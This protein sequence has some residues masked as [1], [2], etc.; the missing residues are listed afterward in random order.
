MATNTLY[1]NLVK[2]DY[3]EKFDIATINQNM[4]IIDNAINS[5]T[6][7][8]IDKPNGI[9]SNKYLRTGA[10][11]TLEWADAIN[12]ADIAEAV[13]DWIEE[14]MPQGQTLAVD[15]TLSVAGAAAESKTTGDRLTA[16]QT[17]LTQQGTNLGNSKADKANTVLT[18]TLSRG[19]AESTTA[20]EGSF[21]FGDNVEASGAYSTATGTDTTASGIGAT[22]EGIGTTANLNYMHAAGFYNQPGTL[23]E[24]WRSGT[25]YHQGDIRRY[26]GNNCYRCIVDNSDSTFDEAKWEQVPYN[27]DEVFVV[28]NGTEDALSNALTVK[29]SGDVLTGGNVYAGGEKLATLSYVQEVVDGVAAT[30]YFTCSTIQ[31]GQASGVYALVIN[32]AEAYTPRASDQMI[33][34][35][36]QDIAAPDPAG[37]SGYAIE[38]VSGGTATDITISNMP[39]GQ[40]TGFVLFRAG[41]LYTFRYTGSQYELVNYSG[42]ADTED[43][44]SAEIAALLDAVFGAQG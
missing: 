40:K 42:A 38:F 2:P 35:F 13:G 16:L 12:Q 3:T 17:A 10:D 19:R 44:T 24:E 5:N 25:Q 43:Y 26:D 36:T 27:G 34:R 20:G 21:A 28:G 23:T 22:A 4:D 29:R 7:G 11:N 41:Q 39:T 15:T 6:T 33:V 9:A 1:L 32:L 37:V 14:N 30:L 18:T 31:A 8:K